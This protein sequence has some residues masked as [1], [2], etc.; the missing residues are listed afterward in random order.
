MVRSARFA[1][2]TG[3]GQFMPF[4]SSRVSLMPRKMRARTA[5]DKPRRERGRRA[6]DL[7]KGHALFQQRPQHAAQHCA[8]DLRAYLAANAA[9]DGFCQSL[10][11]ALALAVSG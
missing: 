2:S 9:H 6:M 5:L 1:R 4:T 11:H 8:P 3:S 7:A 10:S